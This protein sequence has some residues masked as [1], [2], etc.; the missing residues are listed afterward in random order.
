MFAVGLM[1]G[2]SLD[3]IDAA[4]VEIHG[5]YTDTS[6]R[7]INFINMEM[8]ADIKNEINAAC[9]L[10]ESSSELICSLNFKLGYLFSKAAK[11]VC[12]SYGFPLEKLDFIASH[13]QT[14][15]HIPRAHENMVSSTLQIGEPSVIAYETNTTVVSNFRVMDMAAGGQGAPLVPYS[16]FILY[17]SRDK[18]IALQ[19]IGGI[20]N[21][22]VIP[23]TRNID[24]V[25]AFDTGPGNMIIDD[26]CQKLFGV[27][28][29]D[30]GSIARKGKVD[31]AM[32]KELLNHPFIMQAPPKSTGRE[33]FG[34]QFT[35]MLLSN[36]S[37]L[38]KEDILATVTAFTARSIA[39]NYKRF[40]L[41]RVSLDE[42]ILSGGGAYNNFLVEQIREE[43]R[44][45]KVLIQE[46]LGYSS[47]AKEAI[48][49][50]VLGNE[51]LNNNFSNVPSATG[52]KRKVILG[53]ITPIIRRSNE[54]MG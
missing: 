13:G 14:I 31:E 12:K 44:G 48:A 51:T 5:N 24:D 54:L 11:E 9:S 25:F 18:N 42:V 8:P 46:D 37:G 20:G 52:A 29:D 1:S 3:G 15:F 43:L 30:K 28:Y 6:L 17:G 10:D 22:T 40:V 21:V 39:E 34:V 27:K 49:F 32:L 50:A 7:L 23:S 47:D 16:D 53:N 33:E 19:N 45:L 41:Q 38:R 36:F 26:I 2:T 35:N 4:L